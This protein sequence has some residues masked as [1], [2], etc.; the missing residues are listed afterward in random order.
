MKKT[1]ETYVRASKDDPRY[2]RLVNEDWII[3]NLKLNA[4]KGKFDYGM[5]GFKLDSLVVPSLADL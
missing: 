2:I 3:Q 1:I 4:A 5:S